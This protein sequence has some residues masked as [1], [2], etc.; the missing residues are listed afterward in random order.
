M[1]FLFVIFWLVIFVFCSGVI[2]IQ[3]SNCPSLVQIP[4]LF[5]QIVFLIYCFNCVILFSNGMVKSN[6]KS[7]GES[8]SNWESN[9][10]LFL[11]VVSSKSKSNGIS[12][13][14]WE[15]NVTLF[16]LLVVK[17][18]CKNNSRSKSNSNVSVMAM[19]N[20]V[21]LICNA[22][23]CAV[24]LSLVPNSKL[25]YVPNTN[26]SS[27]PFCANFLLALVSKLYFC[28]HGAAVFS[29][30]IHHGSVCPFP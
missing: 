29:F 18:K 14:N 28:S 15:S 30:F 13:S 10:T 27:G 5:F 22:S 8:N 25:S 11:V 3:I 21:G 20:L 1:A 17:S 19:G 2:I 6:S 4:I 9:V 23:T 24:F 26:L 7:N 16:L 12:N